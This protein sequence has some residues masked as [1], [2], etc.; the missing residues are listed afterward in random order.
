MI[1][2]GY[3]DYKCECCGISEWNN[4]D[5]TLQLHHKDGNRNNNSLDNLQILCPNCHSQTDSY[6]GK[7]SKK[8]KKEKVKLSDIIGDKNNKKKY[9]KN[10]PINREDL[11][12]K[13]RNI[14]FVKIAEEYG[15]SDNA[16][17]K[18]CDRYELPRKVSV[19]K[20]Y[21][22]EEWKLI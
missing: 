9:K 22:D 2:E 17:R 5:I 10:L 1:S 3:K 14:P 21:S 6:C 12:D 16:I 11:K 15:V 8:N 4:K 18:W 20:Q 19:I 13:I 7:S